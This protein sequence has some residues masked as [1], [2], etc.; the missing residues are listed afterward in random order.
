MDNL[1]HDDESK[2]TL[3][4]SVRIAAAVI[5]LIALKIFV[6]SDENLSDSY[7]LAFTMTG[8]GLGGG[9]NPDRITQYFVD[10]DNVRQS[11]LTQQGQTFDAML[12]PV[13]LKIDDNGKKY[14]LKQKWYFYFTDV[15]GL[16]KK[17]EIY[18]PHENADGDWVYG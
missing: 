14:T 6:G 16:G 2:P 13:A 3:K 12:I 9:K 17:A 1:R 10:V 15:R 4:I 7:K 11:E 5:I 8:N 18:A